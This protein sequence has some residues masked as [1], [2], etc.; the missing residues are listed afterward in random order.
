MCGGFGN[1]D[2]DGHPTAD[3][4]ALNRQRAARA[5]SAVMV[6]KLGVAIDPD[7]LERFL[8]DNWTEVSD[9][10]HRVHHGGR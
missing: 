1:Y 6:N 2:R 7:Q 10:A 4:K 9:L 3:Q 5:L 8:R